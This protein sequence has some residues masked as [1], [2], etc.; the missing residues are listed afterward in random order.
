MYMYIMAV[1]GSRH[2]VDSGKIVNANIVDGR[3]SVGMEKLML[4]LLVRERMK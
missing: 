1:E 4:V 2:L 3:F